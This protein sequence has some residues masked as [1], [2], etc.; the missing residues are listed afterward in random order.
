MNNLTKEEINILQLLIEE[1][2]EENYNGPEGIEKYWKPEILLNIWK[3]L[4]QL[5]G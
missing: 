5:D 1:R 2:L 3:K 4:E